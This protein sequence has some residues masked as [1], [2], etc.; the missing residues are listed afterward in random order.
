M[1]S[2]GLFLCCCK[3]KIQRQNQI[4][5]QFSIKREREEGGGE[6]NEMV[7]D[8]RIKGVCVCVC[9]NPV[10]EGGKSL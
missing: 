10:S 3:L 6:T 5:D 1:C 2:A 4:S 9:V 8:K 7:R